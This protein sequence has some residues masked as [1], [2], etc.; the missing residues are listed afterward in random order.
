MVLANLCS[1]PYGVDRKWSATARVRC[2]V[3]RSSRSPRTRVVKASC[4]SGSPAGAEDELIGFPFG[5]L[6]AVAITFHLL[7]HRLPPSVSPLLLSCQRLQSLACCAGSVHPSG[8]RW[9][10]HLRKRHNRCAQT[11]HLGLS[12]GRRSIVLVTTRS[13]MLLTVCCSVQGR[14]RQ[15]PLVC[16]CWSGCSTAAAVCPPSTRSS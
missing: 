4:V 2:F 9:T 16:R 13:C 10:G 7:M 1:Q 12:E 8:A 3:L 15:P 11:R 14:A 6:R 5:S